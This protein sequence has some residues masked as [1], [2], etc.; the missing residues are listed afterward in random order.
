MSWDNKLPL[1]AFHILAKDK[2]ELLPHWLKTQLD[3][4]DYPK[5]NIALYFR[6]NDNK[7]DTYNIINN[8]I[9]EQR[10]KDDSYEDDY[11]WFDIKFEFDDIDPTLKQYDIH[12]WNAHRFSVLGKLRQ[13]G[14]DWAIENAYDFYYVCD[15]DNFV[16]PDTLRQLVSY[17]LPV[18]APLVRYAIGNE[19]NAPYANYHNIASERGYFQDNP[20]YYPILNGQVKGLILCDVVHCTYLIRH[21]VLKDVSYA[22]GTEDYEYVIFSRGLR[23]KG[24]PQYLDNSRIYGYLTLDENLEAV[25][26]WMEKI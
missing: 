12:E 3:K 25:K 19:V 18:V 11:P 24:I 16:K 13:E 14:I 17:N 10:G 4:I 21:D 8:W 23:A 20:A 7:D 26:T 15:V 9:D 5:G 6:T 22:D 2:A 1:V